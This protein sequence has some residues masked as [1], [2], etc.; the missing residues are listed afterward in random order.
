MRSL[1][2]AV[3]ALF[4]LAAR[5]DGG[6]LTRASVLML[7]GYLATPLISLA[8]MVLTNAAIGGDIAA[9]TWSA[10]AVAVLLVVEL[11]AMHF[12]H[13]LYF[14]VGELGEVTLNARLAELVQGARGVEHFDDPEV[15][16]TVVLIREGFAQTRDAIEALLQLCGL[17]L[18]TVL[19]AVLLA[20][21]DPWLLLLP[22][23][24]LPPVL[25]GDRAQRVLDRVKQETSEDARRAAHLLALATSANSAK[26]LRL[27][28]VAGEVIDRHVGYWSQISVALGRAHLRSAALRGAGQLVFALAYG[29]AIAIVISRAVAGEVDL[30]QVILVIALAVQVGAQVSVAL[31][32]LARLQVGGL[33]QERLA[34]LRRRMSE[35]AGR[36]PA[37]RPAPRRLARGI[38]LENVSFAY[39]GTDRLVLRDVSLDLPAGGTVAVVGE[40]GS[41]KSTLVKLLCGLYEP[42]EGRILVDGVDLREIAPDLWRARLATLFQDF[43]RFELQLREN[44]GVGELR[45]LHD[46]EALV[47]ALRRANAETILS[48]VPGGLDGLLGLSYGDGVELSGGQWQSLGLSR[49]QLRDDPLL[50][51]LDE[52]AAA[53][54]AMA[55]HT[56]FERYALSAR[57]AAVTV[58]VS[59]R[60]STVRM[61]GSI[62]V[63]DGGRLIEVGGH[64]RLIRQNGLYAELFGLQARTYH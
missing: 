22:L 58:F 30:G 6:R 39:P 59:H 26:E 37:T 4:V 43:A 1:L 10:S 44:I 51:V 21:L 52:P 36:M 42:T 31:G 27:F 17:A 13:L 32:L 57:A 28:H 16:D 33:A 15:A 62:A 40:N 9:A 20:W 56:L 29:G 38:R 45:R 60:F 54:D 2:R 34:R 19:T 5:T 23:A 48:R 11:M 41:G 61:A 25:I 14:E 3:S 35:P 8:L 18:Q 47:E 7:L 63:L 50:L 49:C 53:L 55:E 12:A 24:A 64:E 46:D